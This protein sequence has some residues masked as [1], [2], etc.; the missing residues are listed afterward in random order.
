MKSKV[1]HFSHKPQYFHFW[2]LA[3][4]ATQD[5]WSVLQTWRIL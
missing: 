4:Q 1:P 3:L 2:I 5:T